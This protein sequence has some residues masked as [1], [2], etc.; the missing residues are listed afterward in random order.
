MRSHTYLA[1]AA[2]AALTVAGSVLG[3]SAPPAPAA[4]PLPPFKALSTV[5]QLMEGT[6]AHATAIYWGSVS[7]TI[8]SNGITE[9]FP[10]ND[11]EWE[12]V[13]AAAQAIGES[14]N[15]LMMAPRARDAEWNALSAKLVDVGALAVNAAESKSPEAVLEAGERVYNVCTECHMKYIVDAPE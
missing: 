10:R 6:I 2:C 9:K 1:L 13:W 3:C 11:E 7:T 8:D 14:G 15:L 5:K 4:T 12:A